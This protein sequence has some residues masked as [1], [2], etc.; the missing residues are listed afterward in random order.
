[1]A[2]HCRRAEKKKPQLGLGGLGP[3]L[4]IFETTTHPVTVDITIDRR[5]RFPP[6]WNRSD[7]R[8]LSAFV[9]FAYSES[10]ARQ[11]RPAPE[12]ETVAVKL[13]HAPI[14]DTK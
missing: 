7:R 2:A 3:G 1:M 12:L 8:R 11:F 13:L 4:L 6:S 14:V 10:G 5:I 9:A